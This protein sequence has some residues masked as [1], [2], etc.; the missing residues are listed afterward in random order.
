MISNDD[1]RQTH[2]FRESALWQKSKV[3]LLW[4]KLKPLALGGASLLD[5]LTTVSQWCCKRT[6]VQDTGETVVVSMNSLNNNLSSIL[7]WSPFDYQNIQLV[8]FLNCKRHWHSRRT[9]I[10]LLQICSFS[11]KAAASVLKL[12]VKLC[13]MLNADPGRKQTLALAVSVSFSP[14]RAKNKLCCS[15]TW[16]EREV[17][18]NQGN[19]KIV[20]L[21]FF[22]VC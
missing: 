5:V 14:V 22:I 10:I 2:T 11:V 18:E 13:R 7:N 1:L 3:K 6:G 19:Y 16:K 17:Q 15:R 21:V 8:I 20:S 12:K 9:G 4:L